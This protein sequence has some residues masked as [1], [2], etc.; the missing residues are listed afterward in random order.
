MIYKQI[1]GQIWEIHKYHLCVY[2]IIFS[3]QVKVKC[4]VVAA[5]YNFR[6]N[7][8][9]QTFRSNNIARKDKIIIK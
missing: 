1:M 2:S 7:V 8:L 6:K 5:K 9:L 3:F 4:K